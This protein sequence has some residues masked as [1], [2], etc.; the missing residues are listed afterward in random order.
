MKQSF[1]KK[2][3]LKQLP[4]LSLYVHIPWCVR[5]CPYCDFNSHESTKIPEQAYLDRL[6]EDLDCD[7]V[8]AQGRKLESIFFG[9]GTPS[10]MSGNFYQRLLPAI[11]ERIPFSD[12]I[13]IT[14]EANPGTTEAERF[15]SYAEAGVN[16]LSLGVQSFNDVYLEKLGRIHSA[17]EAKR[18]IEQAHH[19]GITN[20]NIDLMHGLPGQNLDDAMSDIETALSLEPKHLSWYQ[21]TIEQNTEFYRYPPVL[22]DDEH[23][24]E[25]Q[26]QGLALLGKHGFEQ[27]EVSAFSKPGYRALHNLNYWQF[28]DYI[29]VG[30]GAHS[31]ISHQAGQKVIRYRKTRIPNDYLKAIAMSRKGASQAPSYRI[32]EAQIPE[33]DLAFEFL[34]NVLRLK[35]GASTDLLMQ[36]AGMNLAQLEPALS[37]MRAK[38]LMKNQG[39]STT[40]RGLLFL[41]TI[42]ERFADQS[43]QP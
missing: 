32:G 12:H 21:L 6:L 8:F 39:L 29:G 11:A 10:L 13:E 33:E 31:K 41:N 2:P 22:P 26:E 17:G 37:E 23:M 14:L 40:D 28:G 3:F 9:G 43:N 25:I 30:A 18:A 35:E 42:L 38:G 36:R 27:Y 1:L 5:K 7:R 20:C 16:R 19:A 34:M 24:W 4:P 15:K